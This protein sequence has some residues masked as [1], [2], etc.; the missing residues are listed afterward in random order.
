MGLGPGGGVGTALTVSQ[1]TWRL[2][3]SLNCQ[4]HGTMQ[5]RNTAV[6]KIMEKAELL[7]LKNRQELHIECRRPGCAKYQQTNSA[8]IARTGNASPLA[9][10]P[11]CRSSSSGPYF[12]ASYLAG[13]GG[14]RQERKP[15][16]RISLGILL[17]NLIHLTTKK[18]SYTI[19]W[20]I[21][22][23]Y[24]FKNLKW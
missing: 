6:A 4:K 23:I 18:H 19:L 17:R 7:P 21:F 2:G 20:S 16:R 15:F 3:H 13:E 22:K 24:L 8:W 1:L 14:G 9:Q 10:W 5:S 11:R 12:K